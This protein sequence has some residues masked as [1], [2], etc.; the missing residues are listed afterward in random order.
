MDVN[1]KLIVDELE[2]RFSAMDQKWEKKFTELA[3]SRDERIAALEAVGTE[4]SAWKPKVEAAMEDVKLEVRKLNKLWDRASMEPMV[5][6]ALLQKPGAI[7]SRQLIGSANDGMIDHRD[8]TAFRDSTFGSV[9]TY[10]PEPAKGNHQFTFPPVSPGIQDPNPMYDVPRGRHGDSAFSSLGKLPKLPFPAFEGDNPR[11]WISQCESY[12]EMYQV[13]PAVWIRVI[14]MH[15]S[16]TVA[17]WFQAIQR[18]YVELRWPL[19]CKLLMDRFGRDQHQALLRQLFRIRQTGSVEE[20]ITRFSTLMDQLSAYEAM[21][22]PLYFTTR[23]VEGLR[24]DVRAVVMVQR[25][26]DLDTA[27]T[28]ALLQEEVSEPVRRKEWPRGGPTGSAAGRSSSP[29]PLASLPRSR[30]WASRCASAPARRH[31]R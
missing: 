6:P 21:T 31:P 15:L 5:E 19:F 29:A 26:V 4:L 25:P 28:L 1:T 10:V 27:C 9:L 20:Y 2:K 22:D 24:E 23:F 16:P 18:R 14:S 11:L 12:F 8:D 17:C 3:S 7:P 13:D 30:R